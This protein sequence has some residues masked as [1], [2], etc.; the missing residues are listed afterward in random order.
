VKK[1]ED[2]QCHAERDEH[3]LDDAADDVSGHPGRSL[4]VTPC[5]DQDQFSG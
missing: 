2:Q 3:R 4:G 5:H 1:Q